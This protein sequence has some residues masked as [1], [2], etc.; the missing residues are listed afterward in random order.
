[1]GLDM[2]LTKRHYI[3][4]NYEHR[5]VK[6][7]V[8]I[9]IGKKKVNINPNKISY[10]HE[11]VAYWRKANHI[12]AW[13]VENCQG[14]EDD[15]READVSVAKLKELIALCKEI[16]EKKDNAFSEANLPTQSG[17]FFGG[18]EYGEY[19]YSAIED[20]IN[21]LTEAI[22]DVDENDYS[23]DFLYHSSW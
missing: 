1:M 13:F 20:T 2:F 9:T 7:K 21:M 17:F 11:G 19:Y 6:A 22:A 3:G 23:I 8:S 16:F 4:S 14:G 5:N 15:C 18:T 12:H 10:I